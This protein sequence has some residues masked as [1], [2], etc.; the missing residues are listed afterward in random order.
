MDK[1]QLAIETLDKIIACLFSSKPHYE[2][3]EKILQ[4]VEEYE[5]KLKG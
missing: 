1:G 4:I 5:N 3:I 2:T